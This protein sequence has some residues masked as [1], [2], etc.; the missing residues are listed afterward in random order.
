LENQ[1]PEESTKPATFGRR[2]AVPRVCVVD[3]KQH[4]RK[5]VGEALE[6]IGF[7][8]SECTQVSELSTVVD[9]EL[10]HLFV[11][12]FSAG[13]IEADAMLKALAARAFDGNV[14]LFGPRDSPALAAVQELGE[15]LGIAMLPTLPTPF[16]TQG[17]YNSV[18]TLLPTEAPPNPVADVAE[19][20]RFDWLELWYQPKIDTN[21]LVMRGAEALIHMR[22]PTW[23][24]VAPADFIPDQNDPDFRA[25]SEFVIRRAVKDWRYFV[26]QY[27]HVELAINLPATFLEDSKSIE[28]LGDQLPDH[29]AFKGLIV[30]INGADV[31]ANLE[32]LKEAAKRLRLRNIAISIDDLGM[33]WSSLVGLHD[34]PFVEIKV[35]RTFVV[36][37]TDDRLKQTAC[38]WIVDL[39]DGYGARTVAKGVDTRADFLTVRDMGF[40]L[41]Q[42]FLFAKPMPAQKFARTLLRYPVRVPDALAGRERG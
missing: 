24:I 35:D 38:R 1:R 29:P 31:I 17:L 12:G 41:M 26:D 40:D 37:C 28:N 36:G 27:D 6:E 10:P 5:F 18:A 23:G 2:K 32:L 8:T 9:A 30:E 25:L 16:R 34:F 14:L 4:I 22:H 15:Q 20:L 3:G 7:I 19:A 13:G 21:A 42:G 11:V 39:A 33:E